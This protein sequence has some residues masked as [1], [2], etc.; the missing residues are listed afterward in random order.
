VYMYICV[1]VCIYICGVCLHVRV[2]LS[3][4]EGSVCIGRRCKRVVL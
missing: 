3:L 1:Y 4:A 2:Y